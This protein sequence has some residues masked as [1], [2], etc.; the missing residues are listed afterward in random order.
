MAG[1]SKDDSDAKK[2]DGD[3]KK[4]D[5]D[6]DGNKKVASW[7]P[8]PLPMPPP[9]PLPTLLEI[10]RSPPK[11]KKSGSS[12][13]A[14]ALTTLLDPATHC[15]AAEVEGKTASRCREGGIG[16]E[17]SLP[18]GSH[19]DVAPP[20]E[21]PT[22][23]ADSPCPAAM[24]DLSL[25]E[26]EAAGAADA[27]GDRDDNTDGG[28]GGS[29]GCVVDSL[30]GGNRRGGSDGDGFHCIGNV[31]VE[32]ADMQAAKAVLK[33]TLRSWCKSNGHEVK[34]ISAPRHS[35]SAYVAWGRCAKH[36][37]C[38]YRYKVVLR[39]GDPCTIYGGGGAHVTA[40]ALVRRTRVNAPITRAQLSVVKDAFCA[41]SDGRVQRGKR[42]RDVAC[43]LVGTPGQYPPGLAVRSAKTRL[44]AAK[45]GR[46][47]K[48]DVEA[49]QSYCAARSLALT[50]GTRSAFPDD[51]S[52]LSVL[53]HS[54][55]PNHVSIVFTFMAFVKQVAEFVRR[56]AAEM[57]EGL[58]G[59]TDATRKLVWQGYPLGVLG[60]V[61]FRRRVGGQNRRWRH[62]LLPIAFHL[63]SSE[64]RS[65]YANLVKW[66]SEVLRIVLVAE[67]TTFP[68]L[69]H[70]C[71]M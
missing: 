13:G 51:T 4:D 52:S 25:V 50:D 17:P 29:A 28:G 24:E 38:P 22:S 15:V 71:P 69:V 42:P 14:R 31:P 10:P 64:D 21:L 20:P 7:V 43:N 60:V 33:S 2:D 26:A 1:P 66:G 61:F 49:L 37:Q 48:L 16:T 32:A 12:R 40:S 47:S 63:C 41:G 9:L 23:R 54:L 57:R 53:S 70:A 39:P 45:R 65:Q 18:G 8:A 46:P 19:G 11:R 3:A 5:S 58:V 35:G 34:A 6:G 44:V 62:A 30:G 59:S 55:G 27:D 36:E 67:R 56:H 68:S